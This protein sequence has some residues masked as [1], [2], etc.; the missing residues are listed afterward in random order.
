MYGSGAEE[1]PYS[2]GHYT[3][4]EF[5]DLLKYASQLKINIVPQV[6]VIGSLRSAKIAS[7]KRYERLLATN[8]TEADRLH[9][10]TAEPAIS[11]QD[12][13][14]DS[15]FTD[16]VIDPCD[17]ATKNFIQ[18]L[19]TSLSEMYTQ[20]GAKFNT[21]HAGGDSSVKLFS[22]FP[23]CQASAKNQ[24]DAMRDLLGE[25]QQFMTATGGNVQVNEEAVVDP[26]TGT[27]LQVKKT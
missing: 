17:P 24:S 15:C 8:Q 26:D 27:C 13:P 1:N 16:G 10:M 7:H 4:L 20:A 19:M 18:E 2:S 22:A 21:F 6:N 12:G 3:Q 5:V 25:V 11:K 9:L 23:S 14:V